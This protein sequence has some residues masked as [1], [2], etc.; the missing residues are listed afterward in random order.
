[1]LGFEA[2]CA[3]FSDS[4]KIFLCPSKET[5]TINQA[6]ISETVNLKIFVFS[7]F[8]PK[9]LTTLNRKDLGNR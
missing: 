6:P 2:A 1:V 5:A 7:V 3:I 4:L 8:M 9:Q